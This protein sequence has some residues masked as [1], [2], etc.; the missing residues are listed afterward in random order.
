MSKAFRNAT[1]VYEE[2]LTDLWFSLGPSQSIDKVEEVYLQEIGQTFFILHL[3]A[4]GEKSDKGIIRVLVCE[5]LFDD[6]TFINLKKK[7]YKMAEPI[8]EEEPEME[9]VLKKRLNYWVDGVQYTKDPG[10][11]VEVEGNPREDS[12]VVAKFS[13]ARNL[14]FATVRA[15]YKDKL[16]TFEDFFEL[17]EKKS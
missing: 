10:V 3:R 11:G 12:Y 6:L 7:V 5:T 14:Q 13:P 2:G 1:Q 17:R 16:L 8:E 15:D 4:E 9:W